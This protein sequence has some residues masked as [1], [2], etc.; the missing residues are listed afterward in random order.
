MTVK[1]IRPSLA[2]IMLNK[3]PAH[4]KAALDAGDQHNGSA[5]T[6]LGSYV[7]WLAFGGD[8][9]DVK[10]SAAVKEKAKKIAYPVIEYLS[11]RLRGPWTGRLEQNW[12][13]DGGIACQGHPDIVYDDHLTVMDLKT[14]SDTSDYGITYAI[15]KYGY[16]IQLAAYSEAMGVL[17]STSPVVQLLFV[18]TSEPF[19]LRVATLDKQQLGHGMTKWRKACALWKRCHETGIWQGRGDLVVS[20][21]KYRKA[22]DI[23]IIQD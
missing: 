3:S 11:S 6:Q 22:E 14:A 21:S 7:D 13:T 2:K 19:E 23:E 4:A 10:L 5:A 16:D 1:P 18:E 12:V 9:P 17:H 8:E 20:P 15:E